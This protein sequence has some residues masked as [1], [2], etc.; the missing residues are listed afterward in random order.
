MDYRIEAKQAFTVIGVVREFNSDTAYTE[1]PKFWDEYFRNGGGKYI[2]GMFGVCYDNSMDSKNFNYMIAD[3]A[4]G[5]GTLPEEYVKKDI[6]AKTWAIFPCRGA[7]PKALQDVNTKTWGEWL[8]N[9]REY[10]IDGDFDIEMYTD[11]D[12]SSKDY[13]SEI[14]LPVKKILA[15]EPQIQLGNILLSVEWR[16]QYPWLKCNCATGRGDGCPALDTYVRSF[17]AGK[18]SEYFIGRLPQFGILAF[19]KY[20]IRSHDAS[21]RVRIFCYLVYIV[22]TPAQ[23][24]HKLLYV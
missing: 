16:R 23:Q 21:H 13:Y 10:E 1:I 12:N 14:W 9:C 2:C 6:P 24:R 20:N 19:Q 11:G 7:M 4:E 5:K 3:Y 18:G 22:R 8:P 15:P 17:Y